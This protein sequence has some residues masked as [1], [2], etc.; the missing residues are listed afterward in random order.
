MGRFHPPCCVAQPR[1]MASTGVRAGGGTARFHSKDHASFY[2]LVSG[3]AD[4]CSS[5]ARRRR[6]SPMEEMGGIEMRP[7]GVDALVFLTGE[8]NRW[9]AS[10]GN[11]R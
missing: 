4:C 5:P 2:A 6:R 10:R 1:M 11:R 8:E 3:E 7:I 9:T